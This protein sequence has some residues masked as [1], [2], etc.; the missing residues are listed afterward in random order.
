MNILLFAAAFLIMAVVMIVLLNNV[1]SRISTEYARQYALS[2]A[3]ALSVHIDRELGLMTL[4]VRSEAVVDWMADADDE[5]KMALAVDKM[6]EI[7]GELYSYNLYV[8][9]ES[10]HNHYRIWTDYVTANIN[11]IGMVLRGD[12]FDEWYFTCLEANE[13]YIITIGIDHELQRKRVWID[14]K[15]EKDGVPIGVI[16]TGLEFSHMAGELFSQYE[17]GNMRGLIIDSDGIV[18]MDSDLMTDAEFLFGDFGPK[19]DAILSNADIL[20]EIESYLKSGNSETGIAP[21]PAV[22]RISSGQY[23]IVTI[24]PIRSSGWSLIIL[25]GGTSLFDVS[26]FVPILVTA[27]LLL[28]LIA[29]VTS[30]AN[31]RLIFLPLGKLNRS[32]VSLRENLE[33]SIIGTERD[34]EL[35]ELSRT[36][37]DLFA[38]A[39]VDALTGIYNRRFMENN[40]EHIMAMLSRSNGLLS[41]LMLDIDFFKKYNDAFGHDKGDECLRSIALTLSESITRVSDFSARYGGEE[42][43]AVLINTDE[44]G[45]HVVA[46]R[47]LENIIALNI[48]HPGNSASPYVTVS[49]GG[50]SGRVVYGQKWEEYVK[51]ADDALY[52]SKRDGRN[53]FTYLEM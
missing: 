36:I 40:L 34:D 14:Y 41:V 27:L 46:E 33:E 6:V 3:E 10:S 21:E 32:L 44:A 29:F 51:R 28:L 23:G 1:V 17:S 19:Y 9:L 35:G 42:F 16:S 45:T 2:S 7:V 11:H 30:A 22:A 47:L 5:E 25:S 12:P 37:H 38:K 4:A 52:M 13:D 53:R 15:V 48:P 50:T 31:Y 26:Y 43:I 39:N 8:V 24:T 18:H 49:I 20:T